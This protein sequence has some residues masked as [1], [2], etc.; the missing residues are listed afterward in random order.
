MEHQRNGCG[1]VL[2]HRICEDKLTNDI[3]VNLLNLPIKKLFSFSKGP[4]TILFDN[5]ITVAFCDFIDLINVFRL[6]K[7]NQNNKTTNY[8]FFCS[9]SI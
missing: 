3:D 8:K 5:L 4:L 6:S 9:N 2:S 7:A 1:V